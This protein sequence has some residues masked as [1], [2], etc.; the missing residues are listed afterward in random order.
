MKKQNSGITLIAL[1]ITIIILL[2]LA[3]VTLSIVFNGGIIDKSQN[4]VDS[5]EYSSKNEDEKLSD[6]EAKFTQLYNERVAGKEGS[7]GGSGSVGTLVSKVHVGDYI[8]YDPTAGIENPTTNSILKYTSPIGGLKVYSGTGDNKVYVVNAPSDS[9]SET[10]GAAYN[11]ISKNGEINISNG[12]I[13]GRDNVTYTVEEDNHGN[14]NK[15]Q[16]FQAKS[17]NNLWRVLDDGS[18]TGIIK[19][20]PDSGIR[21]TDNRLF[22]MKGLRAYKNAKIELDNVSALFG[23]GNGA[24]SAHSIT[25]EEINSLTGYTVEDALEVTVGNGVNQSW[26]NTDYHYAGSEFPGTATEEK[27]TIYEMLIK[28]SLGDNRFDSREYWIASSLVKATSNGVGFGIMHVTNEN[29]ILLGKLCS[30]GNEGYGEKTG[31]VVPVVI[32]NSN[33]NYKSGE[34]TKSSPWTFQ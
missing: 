1:V 16:Y 26:L 19:I 22:E 33:V 24:Q 34:G 20:I 6:L 8:T 27:N 4:A 2:I 3:G 30:F 10:I 31:D 11:L 17:T 13:L 15:V 12:T 25:I 28:K 21:T 7:S 18:S 9:Y 32:L 5:Y 14:G 23:H 29:Y